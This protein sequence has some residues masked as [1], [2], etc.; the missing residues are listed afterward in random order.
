MR[1]DQTGQQHLFA[2]IDSVAGVTLLNVV[3]S[4]SVNDPT[5]G[6][7]YRTVLNGRSVHR[8]NNARANDHV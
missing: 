1:V 6:N 8:H 3:K 7:S 4:A 5:P 2:E